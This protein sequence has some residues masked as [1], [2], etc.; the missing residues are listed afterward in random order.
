MAINQNENELIE[1]T[2]YTPDPIRDAKDLNYNH[3]Y[4]SV[5]DCLADYSILGLHEIYK[6]NIWIVK[7]EV[8]ILPKDGGSG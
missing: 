1:V 8:I 7:R 3:I 2:I 5:E 6:Y 4:S